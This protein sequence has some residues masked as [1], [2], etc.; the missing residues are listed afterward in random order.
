ME[1]L[2]LKFRCVSCDRRD[3]QVFR[4]D[5]DDE[6]FPRVRL[7]FFCTSCG[8]SHAETRFMSQWQYAERMRTTVRG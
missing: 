8:N 5:T 3:T 6:E 7:L 1:T 4:V 2:R